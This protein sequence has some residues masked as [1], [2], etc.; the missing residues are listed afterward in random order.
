MKRGEIR[1]CEFKA[2]D[3]RRP[4]L[5]L[6]RDS[7]LAYLGEATVAPV[8]PV[9]RDIPSEVVL[10]KSDGMPMECA[11]NCDHI[12][13]VSKEKIGSVIMTISSEKLQDV[14]RAIR[15]ALNLQPPHRREGRDAMLSGPESE[16]ETLYEDRKTELM[17]DTSC[18]HDVR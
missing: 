18:R 1:W 16:N 8:T 13:T 2:P 4:I 14:D 12:Q 7:V 9:I 6:T 15:F 3:K 5:I 10:T 11:I 17:E